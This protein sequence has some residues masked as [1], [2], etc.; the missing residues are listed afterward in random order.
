MQTKMTVDDFLWSEVRR[1]GKLDEAYQWYREAW[2]FLRDTNPALL[3]GIELEYT[4]MHVAYLVDRS[5]EFKDNINMNRER[6]RRFVDH[7]ALMNESDIVT[8]T[9]QLYGMQFWKTANR[10]VAN[11]VYNWLKGSLDTPEAFL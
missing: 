9:R 10:R 11:I 6:Y 1:D 7:V 8:W 2:N 4:I 5:N 3:D